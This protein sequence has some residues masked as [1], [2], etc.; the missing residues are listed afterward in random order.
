MAHHGRTPRSILHAPKVEVIPLIE[1]RGPNR[2]E[3]R[4]GGERPVVDENGVKLARFRGA[5]G[6]G[7]F[8]R[9]KRF[10]P[11]KGNTVL[12]V[13]PTPFKDAYPSQNEPYV[14]PKTP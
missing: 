11:W 8:K 5:K 2:K 7:F 13:P 6:N 14:K 12:L 1:T 10:R 9:T 4:H 3:R